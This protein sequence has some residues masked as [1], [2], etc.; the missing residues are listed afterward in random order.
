MSNRWIPLY[1]CL[2]LSFVL[3]APLF[4]VR[5]QEDNV[6]YAEEYLKKFY[7]YKPDQDRGK[8]RRSTNSESFQ[9]KLMEMQK[10]FGL[11]R[12]GELNEET[13][14]A[15]KKPRCGLSDA[16]DYGDSTRWKNV[17]LTYKIENY[18]PSVIPV[19]VKKIFK[20]AWRVWSDVTPLRFKARTKKDADIMISFQRGDH[21]DNSPF[22]GHGGILAHAFQ[23]GTGIGGDVH[24][25][26]EEIWTA[27]STDYN[28]F[29]VA[30]HEFGHSLG[31]PHSNDPGSVMFPAYTYLKPNDFTL[32]YEDVQRIQDMYGANPNKGMSFLRKVPPK[33]PNKCDQ[34]LSFDAVMRLQNEV[35]FFKDR[36]MWR[37]H[38]E[39]I[40]LRLSFISAIW[41]ALSSG[42]DAAYENTEQRHLVFFKG[43]QYWLVQQYDILE[44]YPKSIYHLGFPKSVK[45]IDAALH[46]RDT[47]E[48]FFFTDN[49]FW[50]YYETQKK[51]DMNYPKHITEMW[52]GMESK[53]DAA[54]LFN[55]FIY[56]FSGALQY[57]YD[58]IKKYIVQTRN[59]N[60][61]LCS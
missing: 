12:T 43:N 40:D 61:W 32:S 31:L 35:I 16:E 46:F 26:H 38:P 17:N 14:T 47:K 51:L 21:D 6:K 39:F 37:R 54:V 50:K 8:S 9:G 41:P 58:S 13:L 30:V 44:G 10:Y 60:E 49:T 19:E 42:I 28:L 1:V 3:S 24:F 52:P 25:D 55:D 5:S 27:N 11:R 23:P 45:S 36:F 20:S 53:V 29:S 59:A 34:N 7:N 22:D 15:M 48:T 57:Q 56:F 4:S 18:S 2:E 33:T